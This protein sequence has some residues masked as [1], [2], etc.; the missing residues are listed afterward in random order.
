MFVKG[1]ETQEAAEKQLLPRGKAARKLPFKN[2]P[3]SSLHF[4]LLPLEEVCGSKVR[5]S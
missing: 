5:P 1:W 2:K 3:E 4:P